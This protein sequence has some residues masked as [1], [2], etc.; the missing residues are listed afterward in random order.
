MSNL[1]GTTNFHMH[2]FCFL[3]PGMFSHAE[4]LR[5]LAEALKAMGL[6][7]VC[8]ELLGHRPGLAAAELQALGNLGLNDFAD[9]LADQV[10][11]A[12]TQRATKRPPV[13]IGHSMGGLLALK[14]AALELASAAV[15]LA[16]APPATE[17]LLPLSSYA[18]FAGALTATLFLNQPVLPW[19][20][21][22][23]LL[24]GLPKTVQDE[25][26][27]SLVPES[28]RAAREIAF[29]WF[30]WLPQ[31]PKPAFVDPAE[32]EC[33]LLFCGAKH[34]RILPPALVR[35]AANRFEAKHVEFDSP[36]WLLTPSGA[37]WPEMVQTI[38]TWVK[39]NGGD[40]TARV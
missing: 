21:R 26:L 6:D 33:P 23:G 25:I 31:D 11:S 30:P 17:L 13:L 18:S 19:N 4:H 15:L 38:G 39:A 35:R 34:D 8:G 32:V 29:H 36:H 10:T 37:A 27:K 2:P 16:P 28:S 12:M 3:I 40:G 14:L 22:W 20:L 24:N 7:A 5:P 9:D 1:I